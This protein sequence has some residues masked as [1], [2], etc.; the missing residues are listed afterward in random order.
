LAGR[1]LLAVALL[2]LGA[3]SLVLIRGLQIDNRL[4]RWMGRDLTEVRRYEEFRRVFGS[5]EFIMVA[6]AGRELFDW[7][8]LDLMVESL[9][10]LEQVPGV[11]AV[12]GL[13][14]VY[15]DVFGAEDA[16]ELEAE[17][18]STPFYH[19]LFLSPDGAVA[20]LLV[21]V[22]P[23]DDPGSRAEIV[24][25]VRHAVQPLDDGGFTV[26]MVGSPVLA[27]A[28]DHVS[29][30]EARRTFPIAFVCSMVI[31][32]W[33]LRSLRGVAVAAT[34][35]GLTVILSLG[36]VAATGRSLSMV[37]SVL[38]SLL[39]VLA[40]SNCI[41]I[42]LSYQRH[43]RSRG[44]QAAIRDALVETTRPC[45]LAAVTTALGFGSLVA[46]SMSP[47][48]EVGAFAAAGIVISLAVNLSVVPS[49]ISW[50][51]V[52]PRRTVVSDRW[53]PAPAHRP[54]LVLLVAGSLTA[55]AF[56]TLPRVP[57]ESNP[58]SFLPRSSPT[59][60]DYRVVGEELAGFYTMEMVVST[61]EVWWDPSVMDRLQRLE[62][63][64]A[65]SSTVSTVLSP[66]DLLRKARQWQ[67]GFDPGAYELPAS[68]AEADSLMASLGGEGSERLARFA[69]ADGRMVRLSAVVNEMD[70]GRFLDLVDRTRDALSSLPEGYDGSITGMV[71]RLVQAQQDL[72]TSQVRSIGLAC[73]VVFAA[74]AIGL[75][76][77]RLTV[78]SLF[79]NIVPVVGVFAMMAVFGVPLDAATVMVASVA[80]GIAVDNTVHLLAAYQ[81]ERERSLTCRAAVDGALQTVGTALMVTTLTACVGFFSLGLSHFVP[82]R[83]FGLLAGGAMLVALVADLYVVPA[84]LVV[85]EPE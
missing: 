39:F 71:L 65:S 36:L 20:G 11:V 35:A 7:D 75:G 63:G 49:M 85:G 41:H 13:P 28:L 44:T 2:S 16:E 19:G 83:D 32:G 24:T 61:P 37:T 48:R 64:V 53:V 51:R 21:E 67:S 42:L 79:P 6:V 38:P 4:E 5:D 23:E 29:R 25:A 10:E 14:T 76:S 52:P 22:E 81:R 77:W 73:L 57:V 15:R 43:R 33:L 17:M 78:F 54:V 46:A 84:M 31:L 26:R 18:T 34:S 58:L 55:A 47:V 8:A 50:F 3:V 59:S 40:L 70:E 82:I 80:L 1:K 30:T 12:E 66:L 68:R 45:T 9:E 27:S 60:E 69:R 62:D 72:V 56:A 74:I